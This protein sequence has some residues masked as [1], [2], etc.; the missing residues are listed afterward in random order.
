MASPQPIARELEVPQGLV[1]PADL[2]EVLVH[3]RRPP[4]PVRPALVLGCPPKRLGCLRAGI[5]PCVVSRP[6]DTGGS[7]G[8]PSRHAGDFWR[9]IPVCP[10]PLLPVAPVPLALGMDHRLTAHPRLSERERLAA[11][12]ACRRQV[13]P[14]GMA[15]PCRSS[16]GLRLPSAVAATLPWAAHGRLLERLAAVRT[17]ADLTHGS[18]LFAALSTTT[19]SVSSMYVPFSCRWRTV[20]ST[21]S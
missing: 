15:S 18:L 8:M 16:A 12:R 21:S 6:E 19:S 3:D 17:G 5:A 13:G 9:G 11:F 20:V 7:L 2:L 1:P 4:V 14:T 10:L